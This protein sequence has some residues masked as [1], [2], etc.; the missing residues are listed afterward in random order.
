[1]YGGM[2]ASYEGEWSAKPSDLFTPA[3]ETVDLRAGLGARGEYLLS[4]SENRDISIGRSG[5]K[6]PYRLSY[7]RFTVD[8]VGFI[9]KVPLFYVTFHCYGACTKVAEINAQS[10]FM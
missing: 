1:M 4:P 6:S 2:E 8:R 7:L 10:V 5:A 9:L 3:K